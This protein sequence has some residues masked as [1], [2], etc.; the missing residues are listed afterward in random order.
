MGV[1][2]AQE[3]LEAA[4]AEC[5]RLERELAA[6]KAECREMVDAQIVRGNALAEQLTAALAVPDL[7]EQG[8]RLASEREDLVAAGVDP[9]VLAVPLHP[10]ERTYE[11][12]VFCGCC[13]VAP[14]G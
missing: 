14:R 4:Q 2:D 12:C 1:N 5:I 13:Q 7:A 10:R 3:M 8:R 9:A 6:V 11:M